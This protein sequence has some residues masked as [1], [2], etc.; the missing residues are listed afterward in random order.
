M[1]SS[2]S[3]GETP[4]FEVR[5]VGA[6]EQ[7][8][9]CPD[10]ASDALSTERLHRLCRGECYHPG[11]TRRRIERIEVVRIR[12]RGHESEPL[13]EL[14]E[15]PWRSLPCPDD[16]SGCAVTFEDPDFV[17]SGRSAVYYVR[18]IQEP[19]PTVNGDRL[20]CERDSDGNC[21]HSRPCYGDWRTP[22]EDECLAS[23]S[24]RAW[25]SPIWVDWEG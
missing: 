11:D 5:A 3:L 18:A 9:G 12:P 4:R 17:A 2:V 6:W 7:R 15:D 16:P 25:S 21:V 24:E 10:Y 14:I 13:H 23:A 1:G 20:R 22:D 19:T 8:P